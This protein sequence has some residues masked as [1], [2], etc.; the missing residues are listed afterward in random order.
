MPPL[1]PNRIACSRILIRRFSYHLE[2]CTDLCS[3]RTMAGM[4][5]IEA[6]PQRFGIEHLYG[7]K[8]VETDLAP[9]RHLRQE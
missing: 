8:L 5:H 9:N 1:R 3:Q 7:C 2:K 6:A 4:N